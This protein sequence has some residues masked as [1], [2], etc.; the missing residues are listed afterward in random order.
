MC[1]QC[2]GKSVPIVISC[3]SDHIRKCQ[4]CTSQLISKKAY[5]QGVTRCLKCR[6]D[7]ICE[8]C[9]KNVVNSSTWHQGV[10]I[11]K[12]CRIGL[13]SMHHE[14]LWP[15]QYEKWMEEDHR[16]CESE[17]IDDKDNF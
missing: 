9:S 8:R 15:T 5:S 17:R 4:G 14:M 7:N 1:W 3:T 12:L 10:T 16:L 6:S 13:C 2:L 11:C